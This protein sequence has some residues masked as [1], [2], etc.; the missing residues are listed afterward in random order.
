MKNKNLDTIILG[1]THFSYLFNIIN[2]E[3]N[4]VTIVDSSLSI[5][6]ELKEYLISNQLLNP[7][8]KGEISLITTKDINTFLKKIDKMKLKYNS[9][10]E[11]NL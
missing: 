4:D 7:Q 9:V 11:I 1:C 10:K 6:D 3:M 8:V 2:D 5:M